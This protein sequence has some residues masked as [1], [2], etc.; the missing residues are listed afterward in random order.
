MLS[1]LA[2]LHEKIVGVLV[3]S[4]LLSAIGLSNHFEAALADEAEVRVWS[5]MHLACS[6][7]ILINMAL[8]RAAVIGARVMPEIQ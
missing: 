8:N 1:H 3:R 5:M 4:S 7:V 2:A 6:K